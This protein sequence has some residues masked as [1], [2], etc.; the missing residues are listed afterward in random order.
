MPATATHSHLS[1]NADLSHLDSGFVVLNVSGHAAK[2]PTE[3]DPED[4][5][6]VGPPPKSS[7]LPFL[8]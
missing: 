5:L 3:V 2:T 6:I 4:P 1:E 8:T 7:R